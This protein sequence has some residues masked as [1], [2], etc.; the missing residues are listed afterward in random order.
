MINNFVRNLRKSYAN[1]RGWTTPRKL[2]LFESDDWGSIRIRDKNAYLA[3]VK[4]GVDLSVSRY[5]MYDK[6]EQPEDLEDLFSTLTKFKDK[7]GNHPVFSAN[8]LVANPDF[9]KIKENNF[10][11][12][13]FIDLRQSYQK[14]NGSEAKTFKLIEQG[15]TNKI[16]VPQFHGKEHLHPLRWMK[17][18]AIS[19]KELK[20]FELDCIPGIPFSKEYTEYLPYMSAFDYSDFAER[21]LA[22][23]SAR[24]GLQLFE[25]LFG[26]KSISF[27]PSQSVMGDDLF[28]TLRSNGVDLSKAGA[29]IPPTMIN[30]HKKVKHD[31]WGYSNKHDIYFSRANANFEPNKDQRDWIQACLQDVA[32]AFKYG[33]PA[34]ISTHRVNYIGGMEE[35]NR[36][37]SLTL[38]TQL[39]K[40]ILKNY[41]DVEF[42]DSTTLVDIMKIK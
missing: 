39:I 6:L 18:L 19:K 25:D 26:Y 16:F 35:K 20:A 32:L 36:M 30:Q 10:S 34:V 28:E 40:A 37:N 38:L 14:Y 41:K 24:I 12:Y 33:K 5:T 31:Y 21:D 29:R 3:L 23:A 2:V 15:I 22:H 7:N 17:C 27:M 9:E 1:Y 42:I 4:M 8:F 13:E 11:G